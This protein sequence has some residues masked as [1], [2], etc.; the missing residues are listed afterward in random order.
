MAASWICHQ[1]SPGAK[2]HKATQL[3]LSNHDTQI[4]MK[5]RN[6][7]CGLSALFI[8]AT[9]PAT[10]GDKD[11][12]WIDP[13]TALKQDPDFSIQ[14]EYGSAKAGA[15]EGVQIVALGDGKFD[16]YVLQDGLP[17]LG[18]TR[19]KKRT[20]LKGFRD[21]EK[22]AFLSSDKKISATIIGGELFLTGVGGKK[23]TLPRIERTSPTL[24]AKPPEGAVVLFDGGLADQWEKGKVENGFLLST[25]CSSKQLFKNY[26]AHLEF[27]TPYKPYARGQKRGNSGIYWGGRWETQVLDSFGLEGKDNQ[28][29]GIYSISKPILNMCLP[30]LAWQTY[31]VDFIAATFDADGK[32]IAW[33]R[34]TVKLNGVVIH[35]NLE[36]A[37]DL[38]TSAPEKGPLKSPAGPIH[39][40]SHDNPVVYRNIWVVPAK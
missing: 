34:I 20:V 36:L 26:T 8:S 23:S 7:I 27:R 12:T 35:D 17:G 31:D 19:E 30:P 3:E 10:A 29:G 40:Q 22:I 15:S 37:K 4:L 13:A 1:K 6:V 33:P 32:R 9:L 39:L 28:C 16:A 38:T 24:K 2:N 18:W 5:L 21:G 25:G 11:M 14:G